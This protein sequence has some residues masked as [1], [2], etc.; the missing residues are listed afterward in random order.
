M[1]EKLYELPNSLEAERAVL[2]AGILSREALGSAIEILQPEDFYN[3]DNAHIWAVLLEMYS[4]NKPIDF[5][6]VSEE[7]TNRKVFERLGGSEF[8]AGLVDKIWTTANIIYHAEI[9]KTHALRRRLI[10]AGNR[11]INLSY[12][13]EIESQEIINEVEKIIFEAVQSKKSSDFKSLSELIAPAF[14]KVEDAYKNSGQK[15]AG[16]P[17][18]F[19]DLDNYITGFQKG[20]L[21]I[22]AARPSMGKTAL[23]LNIAQFGGGDDNNPYILIFS[24]EMSAEQLVRRMFAAEALINMSAMNHGAMDAEDWQRLNEAAKFLTRKNIYIN[25]ESDLN[26]LDFRTKCRRFKNQHPELALIIVDYL[27]L[28]SVGNHRPDSRQQEV[29]EISRMLKIVAREVDC[30]VIALSQL[31]RETE[32]RSEKKPQLSDLRDSGAI[33]QDAD[34]VMLLYRE[35]YYTEQAKAEQ[36]SELDSKTELRLA[37]NRNGNTGTIKLIFQREF[38]RFVSEADFNNFGG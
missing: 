30:P 10:E 20:S 26:I 25:D 8:L 19:A 16:F 3:S 37:K 13:Y 31:S 15:I 33:E 38:T 4:Q 22:L 6:T 28:M 12:R 5:I 36:N 1:P 29:S 11:I 27:Q 9:V 32:K 17:S 21:N 23:A 34:I 18:G 7:L 14:K 2:G 24:L 35:D